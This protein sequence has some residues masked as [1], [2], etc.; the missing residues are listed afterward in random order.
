MLFIFF[1]Q[2]IR[3]AMGSG[4]QVLLPLFIAGY[5]FWT[6]QRFAAA[7]TLMWV[8]ENLINVSV[9]AADAV[10]MRLPL[11]GGDSSQHDWH[12]LLGTLNALG[13]TPAV[14]AV[15]STLGFVC[16]LSG[17]LLAAAFAKDAN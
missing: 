11:L 7:I 17:I 13:T 1:G 6:R 14:A 4:L 10:A 5:F 9:Y 8:G 15:L 16:I 12:Y 3:V 2:F